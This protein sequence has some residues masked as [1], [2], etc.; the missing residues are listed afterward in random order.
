MKVRCNSDRTSMS[1]PALGLGLLP[2]A[3]ACLRAGSDGREPAIPLCV[4]VVAVQDSLHAALLCGR[5]QLE[6]SFDAGD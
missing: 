4:G 5:A 2:P 6:N 3:P 1:W